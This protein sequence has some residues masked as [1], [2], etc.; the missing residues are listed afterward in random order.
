MTADVAGS[1]SLQHVRQ[2]GVFVN[3]RHEQLAVVLLGE[4]IREIHPSATMC[5]TMTMVGNRANV[6]IDVWVEVTTTLA[7]IDAAGNDVPQVRDHAGCNK[8]AVLWRRSR[9]PRDC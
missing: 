8:V 6:R 9:C 7:M 2:H 5:G 1:F 4:C 3:V